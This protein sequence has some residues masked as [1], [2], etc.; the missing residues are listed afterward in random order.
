MSPHVPGC[1]YVFCRYLPHT[2]DLLEALVPVIVFNQILTGSTGFTGPCNVFCVLDVALCSWMSV[3]VL[4]VPPETQDLLESLVP[5]MVFNE[6]PIGSTG[7]TGPSS[8][9]CVLDVILY[10]LISIYDYMY[11][12]KL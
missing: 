8:V 1:H 6:V 2:Q 10:S 4:Q 5:V 11:M 7:F 9:F 3:C 12:K